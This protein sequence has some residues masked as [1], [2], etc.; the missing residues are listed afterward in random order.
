MAPRIKGLM[1]LGLSVRNVRRSAEWYRELF[2]LK[3]ER[4]NFG[5]S[6]WPSDWDEV[7]LR[8]VASGLLIGLMQHSQNT[9]EPFS[10][11]N[12]GLDH[13]EFEVPT[14]E[15]LDEWRKRLDERGVP[16]SRAQPHLLTFRDLDNIQLELFCPAHLRANDQRPA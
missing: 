12:T 8:D 2:D 5:G 10:E 1:Y 15:E 13:V 11:F 9:G 7:L 6:A 3:V 4:E 14:L 16:W